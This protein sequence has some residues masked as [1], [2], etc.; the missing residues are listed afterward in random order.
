MVQ[1]VVFTMGEGIDCSWLVVHHWIPP[2]ITMSVGQII[3]NRAIPPPQK[4]NPTLIYPIKSIIVA[5]T[6]FPG[7]HSPKY[8]LVLSRY[9]P[10]IS[11]WSSW[12]WK[13]PYFFPW[14]LSLSNAVFHDIPWHA[15]VGIRSHELWKGQP[16]WVKA[17][18]TEVRVGFDGWPSRHDQI[19]P[20]DTDCALLMVTR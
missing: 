6:I 17:Y 18:E 3:L 20:R 12:S 19:L 1:T 11:H 14:G 10:H 4:M 16:G 9:I 15:F 2:Y 7:Y 13:I 8:H 5:Q